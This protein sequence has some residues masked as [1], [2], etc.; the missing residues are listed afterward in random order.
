[1]S[2]RNLKLAKRLGTILGI[3]AVLLVLLVGAWALVPPF[4]RPIP[5]EHAIAEIQR[6]SLGGFEQAVLL[7]GNDRRNP[8][9]LFVHG[10]PGSGELPIAHTYSK[11]LEKHFVVA[12]WDQR[13][14]G[15]SC[16][17]VDW[18]TLSLD[19]IVNDTIELA[20]YLG[21]GRKIFVI[22][23]SWGSLVAVW[24]AQRR[25]DLFYA[26]AGTGQLVHRARQEEIS[27]NWVVDRAKE[28]DDADAL[29]ELAAIHPPYSTQAEFKLQRRWLSQYHGDVYRADRDRA[30]L[31]TKVF[32]PEYS[33]RIK[34]NHQRCFNRSLEV[35]LKDR[36][37]VDLLRD[38]R[39]FKI[40]V[41]FFLGRRD[42]NTPTPLVEEWAARLSAPHVE[43][44]WFE[45]A[46]HSLGI[47]SP[48]EFQKRLVEKLLR[49]ARE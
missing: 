8:V 3:T 25:P 19:L 26:Y 42:F 23:H 35:L 17:G 22:G 18:S 16:Q 13:G 14:A 15:A 34:I 10:G 48:D 45:E 6:I 28:A 11:E 37:N 43:V 21:R 1:M 29:Q 5:G 31:L 38:V 36:I 40:P 33:L 9:L 12:H 39:D 30:L 20:Q 44:I 32:G 47:E 41:F 4:T 27:Y 2:S 24:A 7:R 46:G 49:L